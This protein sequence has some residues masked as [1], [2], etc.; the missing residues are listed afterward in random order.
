MKNIVIFISGRGSNMEAILNNIESGVLKG[1]CNVLCVVSNRADAAGLDTARSY[2]VKTAVVIS[3]GISPEKYNNNL[4]ELIDEYNPDYIVLAGYMKILDPDFVKRYP[5]RII[6]IH[7]ADTSAHQ[8]LHAYEW[9]FENRLK[10][11]FITV[12]YVDEGVD[13]GE[14]IGKASVDMGGADSLEEYEK[15]GLAVEHSFYSEMLKKVFTGII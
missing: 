1:V 7:P 14:V 15:R 3:R 5:K 4:S 2:G 8:G 6:N 10:E 9:A 13:T 11:S 12:H